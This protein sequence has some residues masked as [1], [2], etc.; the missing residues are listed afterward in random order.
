MSDK[1]GA[2]AGDTHQVFLDLLEDSGFFR[3]INTLEE[4]LKSIAGELKV[5]GENAEE[6]GTESENL[7]VHVLACESI[8]AVMLKTYPIS[9]ADLRAEI[10]DRTA[11]LTGNEEGSPT[12]QAVAMEIMEK[13]GE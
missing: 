8:L 11:T 13:A 6:R 2:N 3:Q 10:K 4:S 1:V 9:A 7:A 5:F 12:V